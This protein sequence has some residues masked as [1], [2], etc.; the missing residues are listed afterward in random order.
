MPS[1]Y[2]ITIIKEYLCWAISEKD[3]NVDT[4]AGFVMLT[5]STFLFSDLFGSTNSI[6]QNKVAGLMDI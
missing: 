1:A 2:V 3:N 4:V 6:G 5:L